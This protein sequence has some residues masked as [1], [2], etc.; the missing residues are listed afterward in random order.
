MSSSPNG[1]ASA[2]RDGP[3]DFE[4]RSA[5]IAGIFFL[6][7]FISIAALPLY[8]QVLNHTHFIVG[9]SGDTRVQLGAVAEIITLISGIGTAVALDPVL[10]RQSEGLTLGYVAVRVVESGLIALGIVSL[11]VVVTPRRTSPAPSGP[12]TRR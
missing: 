7:T 2:T 9:S 6:I 8:E 12:T 5:R 4:R 10:R 11:L 3:T 1:S